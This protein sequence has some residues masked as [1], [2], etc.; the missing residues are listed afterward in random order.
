VAKPSSRKA[1]AVSTSTQVEKAFVYE[2]LAALN[3]HVKNVLGDLDRLRALGLFDSKFRRESGRIC[4]AMIEETRT[5]INFGLV[6]VLHEHE[7]RDR[8]RF[9]RIRD[10]WEKKFEDPQDILIEAERL[11]RQS[12]GRKPA[13]PRADFV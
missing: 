1:T 9:G 12:G 10:Q 6:E 13:N 8:A 7:E 5:W 3:R 4:Q 2:T 11:R